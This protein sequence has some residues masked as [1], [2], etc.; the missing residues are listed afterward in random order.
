MDKVENAKFNAIRVLDAGG[1]GV[2]CITAADMRSAD[3][4]AAGIIPTV[5]DPPIYQDPDRPMDA[6][7]DDLIRRMSLQE[8]VSQMTSK[9]AGIARLHLLPYDYQNECLHGVAGNGRATVFP[10]TLGNAASFDEALV[11]KMAES[12]SIEGRAKHAEA[13]SRG[14]YGCQ[15]R[16]ELLE[17]QREHLPRP[18]LGS[19]T[20]DL[21]R[22]PLSDRYDGRRL[23]ARDAGRRSPLCP[24][25]G[26]RQTFRRA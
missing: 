23:R 9:S 20:G 5:K 3:N 19:G 13:A 25:A 7:I 21:R 16:V 22:R 24:R 15:P 14:D 6:R 2:A 8:K 26:L 17:P 4:P 10:Q 18:A 1:Q 11:G 12:I